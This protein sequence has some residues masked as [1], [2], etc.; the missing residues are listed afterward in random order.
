MNTELTVN[1]RSSQSRCSRSLSS[2]VSAPL[3]P[4]PYLELVVHMLGAWNKQT[5]EGSHTREVL[6]RGVALGA[7]STYH[8]CRI[9]VTLALGNAS[10]LE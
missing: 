2:L 1:A 3:Q 10:G 6:R 5:G 4:L 7:Q 9:L 8:T